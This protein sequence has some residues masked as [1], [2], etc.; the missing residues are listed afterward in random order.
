MVAVEPRLTERAVIFLP[1]TI[2]LECS[3]QPA[4]DRNGCSGPIWPSVNQVWGLVL[5]D[6]DSTAK[7]AKGPP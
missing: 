4:S 3:L 1:Q 5:G 7:M 2:P 6:S